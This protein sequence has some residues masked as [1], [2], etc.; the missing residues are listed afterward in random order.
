MQ[1][2][3]LHPFEKSDQ[4]PVLV[5][6]APELF[7][8][9]VRRMTTNVESSGGYLP[10]W[11]EPLCGGVSDLTL[12][13]GHQLPYE[14]RERG[15]VSSRSTRHWLSNQEDETGGHACLAS[16]CGSRYLCPA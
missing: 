3:F 5:D 13:R 2:K 6:T 10:G 1:G 12:A 9:I 15:R 14:G 16:N 11:A 8:G 4:Y 7:G